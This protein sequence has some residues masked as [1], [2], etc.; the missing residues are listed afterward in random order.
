MIL[1]PL[2]PISSIEDYEEGRRGHSARGCGHVV[3]SNLPGPASSCRGY[4]DVI[5]VSISFFVPYR[6]V[7]AN[8]PPFALLLYFH[9]SPGQSDVTIS[10]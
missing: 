2:D 3:A 5:T 8:E 1:E 6:S 4:F 7:P 9:S 10:G